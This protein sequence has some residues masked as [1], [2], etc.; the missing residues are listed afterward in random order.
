MPRTVFRT[1]ITMVKEDFSRSFFESTTGIENAKAEWKSQGK[2]LGYHGTNSESDNQRVYICDFID[3][4]TRNLFRVI[5]EVA[6]G[7]QALMVHNSNNNIVTYYDEQNVET[8]DY[9]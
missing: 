3:E 1:K 9:D 6:S 8:S 7:M 4:D 2:I 5:P